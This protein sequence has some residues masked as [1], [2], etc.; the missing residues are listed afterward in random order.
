MLVLYFFLISVYNIIEILSLGCV[1]YFFCIDVLVF[2][3]NFFVWCRNLIIFSLESI[4]YFFC[5]NVCSILLFISFCDVVLFSLWCVLCTFVRTLVLCL[6]FVVQCGLCIQ[7]EL[8]TWPMRASGKDDKTWW[9]V[10]AA[11]E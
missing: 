5:R 3:I 9:G 4:K 7:A 8:Q 2:L 6:F 1:V 10:V 11:V